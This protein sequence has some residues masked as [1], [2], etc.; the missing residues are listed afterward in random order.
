MQHNTRTILRDLHTMLK[1]KTLGEPEVAPSDCAE[2][3]RALLTTPHTA[4]N[5]LTLPYLKKAE[6]MAF[7]VWAQVRKEKFWR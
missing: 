5:F 1:K 3:V 2:D 7:N 4:F 6:F